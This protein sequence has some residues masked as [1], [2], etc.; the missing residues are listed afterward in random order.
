MNLADLRSFGV[1]GLI[2]AIVGLFKNPYMLDFAQTLF[3]VGLVNSHFPS[4]FASFLESMSISHLHG[5]VKVSQ[6]NQL[7][8]GKFLYLTGTGFLSN[9]MTNL[10]LIAVLLFLSLIL[11]AV[12]LIWKRRMSYSRVHE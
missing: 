2:V 7:G 6:P 1:L 11:L 9:T 5:L 8:T 10:V 4:N 12:Y 3:L